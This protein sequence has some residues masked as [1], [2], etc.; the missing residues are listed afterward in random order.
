MDPDASA[1]GLTDRKLDPLRYGA[2]AL[3]SRDGVAAKVAACIPEGARVL[4]VGCGT[5]TLGRH[6][7][8]TR[9]VRIVGIEPHA[10]RANR[11]Q[12]LGLEVHNAAFT[13]ESVVSIGTFD[14]V[15]FADVLEHVPS[16][17]AFLQLAHSLLNPGGCVVAVVPNA[18]HW[19]MRWH[20]LTGRFDYSGCGILDATHL[21]WFTRRSTE[22]LF[23]ATG[24]A[25]T[26]TAY[27]AGI[28]CNEPP[29]I[30]PAP[31]MVAA[32][33]ALRPAW[34]ALTNMLPNLMSLQIVMQARPLGKQA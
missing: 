11:A 29:A 25:V 12:S 23:R 18:V 26:A 13:P 6:L 30:P 24:Y 8:D 9:G 1:F 2:Q 3:D 7:A 28:S 20:L 22:R 4:D 27:T 19:S 32:Y 31:W 16:P 15:L 17:G 14:V 10:G 34:R 33:S 21:R 5:G